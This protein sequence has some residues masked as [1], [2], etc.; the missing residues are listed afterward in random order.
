MRRAYVQYA[1][2]IKAATKKGK[3]P[4]RGARVRSI[5]R[6][7]RPDEQIRMQRANYEYRADKIGN[8]RAYKA[9]DKGEGGDRSETYVST[10]RRGR[11]C[12]LGTGSTCILSLALSRARSVIQKL[13]YRLINGGSSF[14]NSLKGLRCATASRPRRHHRLR[15]SSKAKYRGNILYIFSVYRVSFKYTDL[16][17]Y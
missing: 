11:D 10:G 4:Y 1:R 2:P 13:K 5:R 15:G 16:K 9:S 14:A 3:G 7:S 12:S 8:E 17:R 6:D